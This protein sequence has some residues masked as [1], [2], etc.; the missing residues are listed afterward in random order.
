MIMYEVVVEG[1][2]DG[3]DKVSNGYGAVAELG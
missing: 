1:A 2:V 3:L